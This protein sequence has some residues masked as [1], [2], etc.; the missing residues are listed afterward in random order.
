MQSTFCGCRRCVT[1]RNRF[2][3]YTEA[4]LDNSPDFKRGGQHEQAF[5]S[6][7]PKCETSSIAAMT[8]AK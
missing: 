7:H 2:F 6:W 3:T 4:P 5:Q 8:P 1:A